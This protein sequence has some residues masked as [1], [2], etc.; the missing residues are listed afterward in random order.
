MRL[1]YNISYVILDILSTIMYKICQ[2]ILYKIS[3]LYQISNI[4]DKIFY[5]LNWISDLKIRYLHS[6][7]NI[8]MPCHIKYA[9]YIIK[10][11]VQCEIICYAKNSQIF[12][13]KTTTTKQQ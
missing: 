2:Y 3:Y 7:M 11:I 5:I 4:I 13:N 1:G 6:P 8:K 12:S 9:N 10:Y